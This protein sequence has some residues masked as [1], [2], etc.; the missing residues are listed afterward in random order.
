M[1]RVVAAAAAPRVQAAIH[2]RLLCAESGAPR[3]LPDALRSAPVVYSATSSHPSAAPALISASASAAAASA[4]VRDATNE[5]SANLEVRTAAGEDVTGSD[6]S[7]DDA[8]GV[9]SSDSAKMPVFG[10]SSMPS[11]AIELSEKG[12]ALEDHLRTLVSRNAARQAAWSFRAALKCDDPTLVGAKSIHAIMP[13]LARISWG[14]TIIDTLD[15]ITK[16]SIRVPTAVFNSGLN[17]LM[18]SG[19]PTVIEAKIAE[20]WKLSPSSQP[21]ASSYNHL[22]GA[23]FCRGD[24]ENAYAVLQ[25]MK[26]RMIYPTFATYHTLIAGCIRKGAPRR[27]FETLLAVEQQR[28]DMS[29]LTIGQ[30]LVACA[31]ADDVAATSQLMP[32]LEEALPLYAI[33]IERLS[34]R[35]NV[36]RLPNLSRTSAADRAVMRGEPKL[37]VSGIMST[38][39]AAYRGARPDIAERAMLWFSEWYPDT[40]PSPSAW[41]CVIG[42]YAMAGD[43]ASAFDA[44]SRMRSAGFKPSLRELNESLIKP[45]SADVAKIDEQYFRLLDAL[46][47]DAPVSVDDTGEAL[48]P[49]S[50]DVLLAPPVLK[51]AL[52]QGET[53]HDEATESADSV[54]R[55]THDSPPSALSDAVLT[56]NVGQNDL[57]DKLTTAMVSSSQRFDVG[58]EEFNCIIAACSA[59]GDLDRAFQTYDEAQR[60]GLERTTDTFNALLSG[61]I[62]TRHFKGGMRIRDE[63]EANDVPFNE[64]TAYLLVRLCVRVGEFENAM[65]VIESS[66]RNN[67]VVSVGAFQTLARKLMKLNQLGQVRRVV[68]LGHLNGVSS[69]ATLSRLEGPCV[70]YISAL[71]SEDDVLVRRARPFKTK[72]RQQDDMTE[73][74]VDSDAPVIS[75]ESEDPGASTSRTVVM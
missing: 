45:L 62:Q 21:N 25:D 5:D 20:M 70:G 42:A 38:L 49:A 9:T 33:E 23:H 64:D 3:T 41:Y 19:R 18:R 43:F 1:R 74:D 26:N 72:D 65:A 16:Y 68:A 14:D 47:S 12:E 11:R 8:T 32:R 17:G 67:V 24:M 61:C 40:K 10:I 44:L 13:V 59:V 15:H 71:D 29:A 63:M 66:T 51:A 53:A 31:E 6:G 56:D 52:P 4:A 37:E 28:F 69:Q 75:E 34:E 36:Y 73:E 55:R 7:V 27:A 57:K 39:R 35:R 48:K 50:E 46:N 30:V 2:R 58:I 54:T 60:R 22:I